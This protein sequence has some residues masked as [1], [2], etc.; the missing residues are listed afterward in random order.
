[1]IA[2]RWVQPGY[3]LACIGDCAV[4]YHWRRLS[5][6]RLPLGPD[7]EL[8]FQRLLLWQN[9]EM[10][11]CCWVAGAWQRTLR[12]W[13]DW[14]Y[15][16]WVLIMN[17]IQIAWLA[18]AI[19]GWCIVCHFKSPYGW[20]LDLILRVSWLECAVYEALTLDL[21]VRRGKQIFRVIRLCFAEEIRFCIW[22][23]NLPRE[24]Y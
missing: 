22:L 11:Q 2:H 5:C 19:I 14:A 18:F 6:W 9:L 15:K 16:I 7:T 24:T 3:L 17:S 20:R 12:D 4:R 8:S 1:M 13:V 21:Q 10:R 23:I